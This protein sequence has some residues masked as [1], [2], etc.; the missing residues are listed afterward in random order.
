MTS[1]P[2]FLF[3]SF[4]FSQTRKKLLQQHQQQHQQPACKR[5]FFCFRKDKEEARERERALVNE[6]IERERERERERKKKHFP[7]YY[8]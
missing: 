3:L 1:F 5:R 2:S 7:Y 6:C 8:A 4:L